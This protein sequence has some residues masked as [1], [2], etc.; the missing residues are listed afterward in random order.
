M[1]NKLVKSLIILLIVLGFTAK[2][3]ATAVQD[4]YNE[5]SLNKLY[6]AAIEKSE[7]IEVSKENVLISRI[8]KRKVIS[9][10]IPNLSSFGDYRRYDKT[11]STSSGFTIQPEDAYTWGAR[12]EQSFSLGGREFIALNMSKKKIEKNE[13]DFK[14]VN[15]NYLLNVAS[16]YY[17]ILKA[18]KT[19][20]IAQENLSRLEKHRD[21]AK[22]RYQVGEITKT[23]VL[24]AQ[25]EVSQAQSD[26][27][28]ATNILK[29]ANANLI[30]LAGI[31]EN[32]TVE[33]APFKMITIDE[34]ADLK[35][36]ALSNR[37]E[38]KSFDLQ[39]QIAK[40][41]VKFVK[42]TYLPDIS[43]QAAYTGNEVS[44]VTAFNNRK[45]MYGQISLNIPIVEGGR[46][47]AEIDEANAKLRQANLLYT[48][49]KDTINLEVED[50]Y[51]NLTTQQGILGKI[52]DQLELAK[53]NYDKISEQFKEGF[54][55]NIDLVDANNFLLS[56]EQQLVNAQYDYQMS[57]LIIKRATGIFL[58][59]IQDDLRAQNKGET[60]DEAL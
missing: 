49:L 47:K 23:V 44:P 20:N 54:A 10:F 36:K 51:Y 26:M 22:I 25:A 29:I 35:E 27:I 9:D 59:E 50:A 56:T 46:R 5:Y 32:F 4:V 42:S 37:T 2:N 60:T 16:A 30:K 17:N 38:L 19:L 13:I 53:D 33:A 3:S 8:Q 40:D 14:T 48:D 58:K 41:Q 43:L 12:L 18:Q 21:V 57:I 24:R 6:K 39:T 55:S 45:V 7:V 15:E 1:K 31:E 34:M 52:Q 28:R 11:R